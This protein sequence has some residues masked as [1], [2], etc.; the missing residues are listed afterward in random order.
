MTEFNPEDKYGA[1]E[2]QVANFSWALTQALNPYGDS[3]L[4]V[5]MFMT[6]LYREHKK[7][8]G[9]S[10]SM[11][12]S[13]VSFS[14]PKRTTMRK[15]QGG[16]T[17]MHWT[18]SSGRN[19]DIL[20]MGFQGQTGNINVRR[21]MRKTWDTSSPYPGMGWMD[22]VGQGVNY[23]NKKLNDFEDA[24]LDEGPGGVVPAGL[25]KDLSGV[26]KLAKFWDLYRLTTEPVLLPSG[27]PNYASI[28]Y[29][30]VVFGN[31]SVRFMGHFDQVL[32]FSDTADDPFN[33]QYTFSF[34]VEATEPRMDII[35]EAVTF[36]LG[37]QF[38]NHLR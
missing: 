23:A 16:T 7:I 26:T 25:E 37:Q 17:F 28:Y 4:R 31:M 36:N 13:S 12:P 20:T 30:S 2:Y 15:T 24:I 38:N 21:G 1:S 8:P 27:L 33:K 29:S 6:S 5:P 34:V 35:Y 9:L 10:M 11:N 19:N 3:G 18:D 14:Q 22:K 32:E